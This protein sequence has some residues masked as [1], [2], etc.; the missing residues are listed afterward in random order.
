VYVRLELKR[1]ASR[2]S[3]PITVFVLG[4]LTILASLLF[5]QSIISYYPVGTRNVEFLRQT[6]YVVLAIVFLGL[7]VALAG[8]TSYFMHKPSRD[9]E[10]TST[11]SRITLSIALNDKRSFRAFV[12][13]ALMYGLFFGIL[14]SLFV[15]RPFEIFSDAYG[16]SVPS[17]LPVFCCAPFGQMPQLVIY[18]TQQFAILVVPA[19]LILLV[20]VSW[21]VG[22]NAG[23]ATFAYKNRPETASG[24]WLAGFG[25]IVGLFTACPSCAGFFLLTMLGLT[26]AVGLALTLSSLQSVFIVIGLPI[27]LITPILTSRRLPINQECFVKVEHCSTPKNIDPNTLDA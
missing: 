19:N 20:T 23:I 5:Y 27:L 22:L 7:F 8:A 21:L 15:Y 11:P 17:V 3:S 14:S 18:L 6:A 12:L 9:A 4:G 26:G 2:F 24:R 10:A 1:A 25:A 13:S 16:V